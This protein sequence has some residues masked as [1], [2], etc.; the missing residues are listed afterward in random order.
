MPHRRLCPEWRPKSAAQ[1]YS[2]PPLLSFY[3]EELPFPAPDEV[4]LV[5]EL[6]PDAMKGVKGLVVYPDAFSAVTDV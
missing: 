6:V 1:D 3:D 2:K 4:F 5:R